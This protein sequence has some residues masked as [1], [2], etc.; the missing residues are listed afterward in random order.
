MFSPSKQ[1]WQWTKKNRKYLFWNYEM[2]YNAIFLFLSTQFDIQDSFPERVVAVAAPGAKIQRLN[3]QFNTYKVDVNICRTQLLDMTA[4]LPV[5]MVGWL[6]L[7]LAGFDDRLLGSWRLYPDS[8][9]WGACLLPFRSVLASRWCV[10]SVF[11][12][13]LGEIPCS[14]FPGSPSRVASRVFPLLERAASNTLRRSP[15]SRPASS[16][17]KPIFVFL[18]K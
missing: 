13:S 4:S 16:P 15:P 18:P 7:F 11:S 2:G 17:V 1:H 8:R 10:T 12:G 6:L 3:R 9:R 5:S 14:N